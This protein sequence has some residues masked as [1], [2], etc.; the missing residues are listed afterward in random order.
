MNNHKSKNLKFPLRGK[1]DLIKA[2]PLRDFLRF[3]LKLKALLLSL[4]MVLICPF[5]SFP[6]QAGGTVT[7]TLTYSVP[8]VMALGVYD[9]NGQ[10]NEGLFTDPS[11]SFPGGST[12]TAAESGGVLLANESNVNS[13]FDLDGTT[14]STDANTILTKMTQTTNVPSN[15]IL[16]K[17]AVFTNASSSPTLRLRTNTSQITL[18][19]GT[20]T[21]PRIDFSALGGVPGGAAGAKNSTTN[22]SATGLQI[23]TA[24]RNSLGYARFVIV[25]DYR[26]STIDF[27]TKGNW[28]GNL[29]LTLTGL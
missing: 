13:K 20:G 12:F 5:Q 6:S 7:V 25:G 15:D 3:N 29:T 4:A 10:S 27:T 2:F 23:T 24:R 28:T 8:N 17:G 14:S 19:G 21:A 18:T 11:A 9:V 26:E 16:I 1:A 22:P